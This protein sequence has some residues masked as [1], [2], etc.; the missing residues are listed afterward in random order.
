MSVILMVVLV[1]TLLAK[2]ALVGLE[3]VTKPYNAVSY[4]DFYGSV[5]YT[6]DTIKL[7]GGE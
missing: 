2:I 4:N 1:L 5:A 3:D 7:E 6:G